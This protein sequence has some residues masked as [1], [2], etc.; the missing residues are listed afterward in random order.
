[1]WAQVSLEEVQ[2]EKKGAAMMEPEVGVMRVEGGGRGL[3]PRK[4]RD[5]RTW[6]RQEPGLS[7]EPQEETQLC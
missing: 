2:S 7:L 5:C 4:V 1:M 3:E 6:K